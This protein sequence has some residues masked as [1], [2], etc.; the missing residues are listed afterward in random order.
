MI[1]NTC[2][3]LDYYVIFIW[4]KKCFFYLSHFLRGHLYGC[5]SVCLFMQFI[6][7]DLKYKT[8]LNWMCG[9]IFHLLNW[10][11][12]NWVELNWIERCWV[13]RMHK[14]L[15]L[16]VIMHLMDFQQN[17]YIWYAMKSV[18]MVIGHV[19]YYTMWVYLSWSVIRKCN[20]WQFN[21]AGGISTYIG[22]ILQQ[23]SVFY[24]Y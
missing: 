9:S 8:Y 22:D 12:L 7:A 21:W 24:L 16:N 6:L 18:W 17:Y 10:I 15:L 14:S 20:V 23:I 13:L 19:R 3:I 4:Y 5:V 11:E 1:F 2:E